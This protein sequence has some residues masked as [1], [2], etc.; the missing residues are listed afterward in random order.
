MHAKEG[1]AQIWM[2]NIGSSRIAI[3]D[4]TNR[5]DVILGVE[6]YNYYNRLTWDKTGTG[7]SG[8]WTVE[9][10]SDYDINN[11]NYWDPGETVKITAYS[12]QIPPEGNIV[13][14]QFV[15]PGGTLRSTEFTTS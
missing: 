6:F 8:T 10:G 7:N 12:T 11:N 13:Y 3:S 5:S 2:K 4:V 15:L 1:T 14:F 9:F